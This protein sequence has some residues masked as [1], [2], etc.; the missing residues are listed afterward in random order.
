MVNSGFPSVREIA[1]GN[2]VAG[3]EF[4]IDRILFF[5]TIQGDGSTP[6]TVSVVNDGDHGLSVGDTLTIINVATQTDYN[7]DIGVT[8]TAVSSDT[9]FQY[10]TTNHTD[11]TQD[12]TG[13]A[14]VLDPY[15]FEDITPNDLGIFVHL[16]V[17]LSSTS[18]IESTRDGINY[19]SIGNGESLVGDI[20]RSFIVNSSD[21]IN[22]R[23]SSAIDIRFGR[24]YREP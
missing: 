6:N 22:F 20:F 23:V 11:S 13:N 4:F 3:Q 12:T 18:I 8:V 16:S 10:E 5:S 24:L 2:F 21:V 19:V 7:L 9:E 1:V 15:I 17:G 14:R